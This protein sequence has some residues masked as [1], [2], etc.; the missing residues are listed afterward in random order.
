LSFILVACLAAGEAPGLELELRDSLVLPTKGEFHTA[1][2]LSLIAGTDT[3]LVAASRR[4]EAAKE[5]GS[6]VS[7]V[8]WKVEGATVR[9]ILADAL[10]ERLQGCVLRNETEALCAFISAG[11]TLSTGVLRLTDGMTQER[12][13]VGSIAVETVHGMVR[14]DDGGSLLFGMS[15]LQSF[16]VL[17]TDGGELKWSV[18]WPD[19]GIGDFYDGV[20][21]PERVTLLARSRKENG[22]PGE[23]FAV[24]DVGSSGEVTGSFSFSHSD[25]QTLPVLM[26]AGSEGAAGG[27]TPVG[28]PDSAGS[29]VFMLGGGV[30]AGAGLLKWT[31]LDADMVAYLGFEGTGALL[32]VDKGEG[33]EVVRAPVPGIPFSGLVAG[34]GRAIYVLTA[35]IERTSQPPYQILRLTHFELRR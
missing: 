15:S 32:V 17:L 22:S 7:Q 27:T 33:A 23:R 5:G 12:K 8:V 25:G 24:I 30:L 20:V 16:A 21:T 34:K 11:G 1:Q 6:R 13:D 28:E 4:S 19:L 9:R 35:D 29:R 18:R 3:V 26:T 14:T 10:D 2:S 31:R